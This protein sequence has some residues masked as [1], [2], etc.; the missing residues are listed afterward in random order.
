MALGAASDW[1]EFFEWSPTAWA[2]VGACGTMLVY[3]FIAVYAV[4]QV[5]EA[6]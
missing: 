3:V 4:V 2:A 6:R 1:W 5:G